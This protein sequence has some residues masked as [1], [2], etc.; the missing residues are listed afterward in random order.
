MCTI[1]YE[2]D[3]H[4]VAAYEGKRIVGECDYQP[5]DRTWLLN[6]V[7]VAEDYD[8]NT[9]NQLMQIVAFQARLKG[10]IVVPMC[11]Y[12]VSWFKKNRTRYGDIL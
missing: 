7:K 1:Y 10:A 6:R 4:R 2:E 9:A 5:M 12:A 3:K 8:A 11:S